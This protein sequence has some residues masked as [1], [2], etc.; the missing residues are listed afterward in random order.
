M[1]EPAAAAALSVGQANGQAA[2]PAVTAAPMPRKARIEAAT[3]TQQ[4]LGAF[5]PDCLSCADKFGCLDPA[6]K[7][8][9]TCEGVPGQSKSGGQSETALCLKTL[10][11]IF[12]TKCGNTGEESQCLCGSTDVMDCMSGKAAPNG[13]CVDVFK[14]D[15]GDDGKK[16]YDNFINPKYGAGRANQ[17]IQCA[18]SACSACRAQ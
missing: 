2:P 12:N 1:P 9:G 3:T 18:V 13:S 10:K 14:E 8:G 16:M 11:C 5:S 4:L 17:L 15:L 6:Q 7:G